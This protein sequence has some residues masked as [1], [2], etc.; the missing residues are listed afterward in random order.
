MPPDRISDKD[1]VVFRNRSG[2]ILNS[3]TGVVV[4]FLES[5]LGAGSIFL[6]IGNDGNYLKC[7][8]AGQIGDSFSHSRGVGRPCEINHQH[9]VLFGSRFRLRYRIA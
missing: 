5:Y 8:R 6:G 4:A 9:F 2:E 7:V 1:I 3:G